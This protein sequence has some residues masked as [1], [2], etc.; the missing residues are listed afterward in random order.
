MY[1]KNFECFEKLIKAGIDVNL[2]DSDMNTALHLALSMRYYECADLLI[3]C[4]GLL[5][6]LPNSV[7][8]VPYKLM[9]SKAL[10]SKSGHPIDTGNDFF[11]LSF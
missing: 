8:A 4:K 2:Q 3:E 11:F 1:G 7:G 10:G 9:V 6:D 5:Y